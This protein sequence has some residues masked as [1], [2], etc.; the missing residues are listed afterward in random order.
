MEKL[1]SYASYPLVPLQDARVWR[2]EAKRL[3]LDGIDPGDHA[4]TR[5]AKA[6]AA[7]ANSFGA[8]AAEYLT[9]AE[10]DRLAER[11]LRKKRWLLGLVGVDFKRRPIDQIDAADVLAVLKPVQDV[12]RRSS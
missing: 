11:T 10:K 5:K 6:R 3:L 4:R 2:D 12:W 9:K 7:A 8:V 1:L